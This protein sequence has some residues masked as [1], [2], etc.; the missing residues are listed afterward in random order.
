MIMDWKLVYNE[1][2]GYIANQPEIV[3]NATEISIPQ[4]VRDEFYDRFD[5]LRRAVVEQYCSSL[6]IDFDALSKSYLKIEKEVMEL[7]R[8]D[9]ISMPV[10]LHSFVHNPKDG[11]IRI[12]YNRTFDLLQGKTTEDAYEEQAANDLRSVAS[13]LF[14]LGY[15]QWAAL[16]L[17]KLLDPDQAFLVELDE[18]YKPILGELKTIAFGRQ[19]HH[20]TMRIPEFVLHSRKLNKYVTVKMV[21]AREI[22]TFVVTVKPPV[23][24]RKKTGDTSFALDSRAMMLSFIATPEEIPIIADIYD[25]K[26]TSPDW[27]MEY[28]SE[29]ELMD[30]DGLSQ[31]KR[32]L[33]AMNPRLGTC[34]VLIG[35][36]EELKLEDIPQNLHP[37]SVAFDELGLRT[38]VDK[39]ALGA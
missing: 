5:E 30:P 16:V 8:L 7:L 17:I 24:P 10:D 35:C 18:D 31:I 27:I 13:E 26:L 32:N 20:P 29:S 23:R 2:R 1:F 11:L 21:L 34:L 36:K 38:V 39:L 3:I 22:E 9:A 6:P 4:S 37:V 25:R 12:L 33:Q 19:A 28:I 15:E 14:R